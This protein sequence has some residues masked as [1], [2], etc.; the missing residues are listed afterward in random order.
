MMKQLVISTFSSKLSP[1]WS[2]TLDCL[3]P[4]CCAI[5]CSPGSDYWSQ[6]NCFLVNGGPAAWV[7][8]LL[9]STGSLLISGGCC[10]FQGT[11]MSLTEVGAI[12]DF[13]TWFCFAMALVTEQAGTTSDISLLQSSCATQHD[14]GDTQGSVLTH[15][16]ANPPPPY[17]S[18]QPQG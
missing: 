1:S 17:P 6:L 16:P 5:V 10:L 14:L 12:I 7:T 9:L 2:M 4:A 15:S 18:S 3:S 11:G 8:L 13:S